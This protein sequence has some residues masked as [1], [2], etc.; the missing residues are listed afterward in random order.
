MA[1][2]WCNK[3]SIIKFF[4]SVDNSGKKEE[5]EESDCEKEREYGG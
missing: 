3:F 2:I 1:K 4:K 5:A